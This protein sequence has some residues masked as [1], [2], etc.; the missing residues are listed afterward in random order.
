MPKALFT[1]MPGTVEILEEDR[2]QVED[3]LF[4]AKA[5]SGERTRSIQWKAYF[6]FCA[7]ALSLRPC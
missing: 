3:E 6:I 1:I 2:R 7:S 5:P 4:S